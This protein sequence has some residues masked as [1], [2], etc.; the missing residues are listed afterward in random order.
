MKMINHINGVRIRSTG[1]RFNCSTEKSMWD[2]VL[3][4]IEL[5]DGPTPLQLQIISIQFSIIFI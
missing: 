2:I 3:E 1:F 5:T 4:L